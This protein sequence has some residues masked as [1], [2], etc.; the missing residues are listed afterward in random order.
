LHAIE[1]SI[2][3]ITRLLKHLKRYEGKKV[4]AI[5]PKAQA[6]Q[7]FNQG[8]QQRLQKL[9]YTNAVNSWFINPTTGKNTLIWPG[10]QTSFWWSRCIKGI[11]WKDW[12]IQTC[13]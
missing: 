10:S 8:I 6:E 7:D 5:V 13:V 1:C 12:E 9:V 4:V 11:Q 2:I 3:Y